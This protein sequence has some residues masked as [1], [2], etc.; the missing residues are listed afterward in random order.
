[1]T[2]PSDA[3]RP[4]TH[5]GEDEAH[6]ASCEFPFVPSYI[7]HSPYL[8]T[9]QTASIVATYYSKATLSEAVWLVPDADPQEVLRELQQFSGDLVLVSHQPL[10]SSLIALLTSGSPR[11]TNDV[12]YLGPAKFVELQAEVFEAGCA[13]MVNTYL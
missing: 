1:M 9:V 6:A 13:D 4:L 7:I 2:A 5:R 3:L 10:V 11:Y 12:P 8:R